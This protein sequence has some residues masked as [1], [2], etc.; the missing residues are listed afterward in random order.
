[1]VN[2]RSKGDKL[3]VWL[4]DAGEQESITRIGRMIKERL[5]VDSKVN[6]CF[7][8]HNEEKVKPGSSSKQKYF[9]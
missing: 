5:G 1:M 9:V 4:A 6:L 7:N 3:A 8:V 2:V